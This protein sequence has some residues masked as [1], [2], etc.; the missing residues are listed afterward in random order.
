M[1]RG[2]VKISAPITF[3]LLLLLC[4]PVPSVADEFDDELEDEFA[5][6]QEEDIV[7]TAAKH[8]QKIGF[9]PSAVIVITRRQIEE[10]G[11]TTLIDLLRRYPPIHVYEFD[12]FYPT[13]ELRGAKNVLLMLDGRELNLEIFAEPFWVLIP[14]GLHEIERIEIVLGPNS[15]LYG[16]NAVVAVVNIVTRRPGRDFNVDLSV[17]AGQHGTTMI[18]GIL[19]G[20]V[21]PVAVQGSF[22]IDRAD[23]WMDRDRVSKDLKRANLKLRL[24]LPDGAAKV[25]GGLMS[26]R[27]RAFGMMGYMNYKE[28]LAAYAK[29]ELETGGLKTRAYWYAVRVLIDIDIDLKL[30]GT[31][32]VLGTVPTVDLGG[33]TFHLDAQYNLEPF[34][35]NLLIAG[36]DFRFVSFRTDQ[37]VD[38]EIE[39]YRFGL[40]LHDEHR[41]A[42]KLLLTV[43]AR[44][45][46][47]STTDPAVSP[48]GALVYNPGGEHF[49]RLSGS[50]AFRKPTILETHGDFK[51]DENPVFP[52][53]GTLFE[54]PDYG[55][56]NPDLANVIMTMIELGYRGSL[57]EKSL[58]LG[59]DVYF[60]LNRNWIFFFTNVQYDNFNRIDLKNSRIGFDNLGRDF[61]IVGVE[62]SIEGNPLDELTLFFRGSF[63][64]KYL[65]ED[66]SRDMGTPRFLATGG[67][68]LRLPFGLTAHLACTFVDERYD[69]IR[70]PESILSASI[71]LEIPRRMYLLGAL[72]RRIEIAKSKVDLG[73]SFFFPLG[74]RFREKAGVLTPDGSNYGGE[75]IGRRVMLTARL[76]Y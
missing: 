72:S 26:G 34:E 70:D 71:P 37:M 15:A 76:L 56:G 44:F 19:G 12:P 69:E 66:N 54:D 61:N 38:P 35:N 31:D 17:A 47:N 2:V 9:S 6:L 18:E 1:I 58:R 36:A 40:F 8:K 11:A 28:S 41:F 14:V 51:V 3:M 65:V 21:G 53:I 25:S 32:I 43:G 22:G 63:R 48:R 13:A 74:G 10:S 75:L 62:L 16:A 7:L 64:H 20:G 42:E 73:F 60:G 24:D 59:A 45:D 33:D 67:G 49:L 55:I 30:S 29:A 4:V 23:S 68:T 52:E 46:W 39:E 57:L 5:L 50:T 27:G